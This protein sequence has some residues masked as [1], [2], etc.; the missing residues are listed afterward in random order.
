[1][2]RKGKYKGEPFPLGKKASVFQFRLFSILQVPTREDVKN[3]DNVVK[4][5]ATTDNKRRE[6]SPTGFSR[7]YHCKIVC[8]S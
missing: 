6:R 4:E 2:Y 1:M 5:T 8:K 3:G 7:H